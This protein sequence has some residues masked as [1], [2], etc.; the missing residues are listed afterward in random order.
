MAKPCRLAST[1]FSLY[2]LQTSQTYKQRKEE[3]VVTEIPWVSACAESSS[4]IR[5]VTSANISDL[6]AMTALLSV[7]TTLN[8]DFEAAYRCSIW[9]PCLFFSHIP[10]GAAIRNRIGYLFDCPDTS[11]TRLRFDI[12]PPALP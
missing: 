11:K 7:R 12:L 3:A 5:A 10:P 2:Q 9:S 8:Q 1:M 4:D 6:D